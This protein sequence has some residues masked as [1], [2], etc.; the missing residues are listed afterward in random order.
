LGDFKTKSISTLFLTGNSDYNSVNAMYPY[1][2]MAVVFD[3]EK[4]QIKNIYGRFCLESS[5]S[6]NIELLKFD[7]EGVI[8]SY[9]SKTST[10]YLYNNFPMITQNSQ[11]VYAFNGLK[12]FLFQYDSTNNSW[13]KFLGFNQI[14]TGFCDN[15]T[16]W[17]SCNVRLRDVFVNAKGIIYFLD[18]TRIRVIDEESGSIQTIYQP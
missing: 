8:A 5:G 6:C 16:M 12:S 9:L 13:T 10:P 1:G 15:G 18:D 11:Q 7:S 3:F 2:P 17:N 4:M 14:A